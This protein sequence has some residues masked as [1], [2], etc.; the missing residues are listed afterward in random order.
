MF[1]RNLEAPGGAWRRAAKPGT[2]TTTAPQQERHGTAGTAPGGPGAG[3]RFLAVE[4][5]AERAGVGP[6]AIRR[7][8]VEGRLAGQQLGGRWLVDVASLEAYR[9]RLEERAS[10]SSGT[11]TGGT[12]RHGAQPGAGQDVATAL[13]LLAERL[14]DAER[15]AAVAEAELALARQQLAQLEAGAP[16]AAPSSTPAAVEVDAGDTAQAAEEAPRQPWW[17]RWWAATGT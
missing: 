12:A 13:A 3:G 8:L 4:E 16:A 1:W 10:R 5:A 15:R 2:V 17:R 11:V 14:A 9:H 6:R 7:A